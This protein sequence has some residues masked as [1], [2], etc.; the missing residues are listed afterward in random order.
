MPQWKVDLDLFLVCMKTAYHYQKINE[1]VYLVCED[2]CSILKGAQHS[3]T[4]PQNLPEEDEFEGH[5]GI[6]NCL[7]GDDKDKFWIPA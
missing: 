4:R 1:F 7:G 2:I 5:H 3:A 6:L